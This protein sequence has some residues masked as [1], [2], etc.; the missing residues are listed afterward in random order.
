MNGSY[1]ITALTILFLV[2]CD[3]LSVV[4]GMACTPTSFSTLTNSK[5]GSL[6][7]LHSICDEFHSS[8]ASLS[9]K[10]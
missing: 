6:K 1:C 5:F 2:A 3:P 10:S 7:G 9:V 8:E 4:S